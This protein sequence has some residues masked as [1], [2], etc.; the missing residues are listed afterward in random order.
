MYRLQDI[1]TIMS[2]EIMKL[3]VSTPKH[4]VSIGDVFTDHPDFSKKIINDLRTHKMAKT[5]QGK[6]LKKS[7]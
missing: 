2:Y 3:K 5:D 1:D 7:L 6:R 4:E